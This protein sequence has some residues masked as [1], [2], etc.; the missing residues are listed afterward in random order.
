M[1]VVTINIEDVDK[2]IQDNVDG[3]LK[4]IAIKLTNK[5]KETAPVHTGRLRNSI[6]ILERKKGKI[7]VG[8]NAKYA[9]ALQFGTDPFWP[10]IEPLKDWARKKLGAEGLAY[11]VQKKIAGKIE[12]KEGGITKNPFVTRAIDRLRQEY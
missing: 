1:P 3:F 9:A 6:T 11:Y 7:V 12:D 4:E 5:L 10:P 2:E 8:V